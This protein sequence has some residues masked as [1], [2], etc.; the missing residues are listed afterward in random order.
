[1]WPQCVTVVVVGWQ[2]WRN[3]VRV[4]IR[5]LAVAKAG[6]EVNWQS[7][8]RAALVHWVQCLHL[9]GR[10]NINPTFSAILLPTTSCEKCLFWS[11]K[12]HCVQLLASD[13]HLLG[14]QA[15][16]NG[17]QLSETQ[18]EK[19]YSNCLLWQQTT[20]ESESKHW[21][22]WKVWAVRNEIKT[23]FWSFIE[24]MGT[25]A[26][27]VTAALKLNYKFSWISDGLSQRLLNWVLASLRHAFKNCRGV[28][29]STSAKDV[30][31]L[32]QFVCLFVYSKITGKVLKGF[33]LKFH[34]RWSLAQ[35]GVITWCSQSGS[36]NIWK[37]C[38]TLLHGATFNYLFSTNIT[39]Y[40]VTVKCEVCH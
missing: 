12:L 24:L 19:R 26:V 29:M 4:G 17:E 31:W 9:P 6:F 8:C 3:S 35:L 27:G 14:E 30:M 5:N 11:L 13:Y 39:D 16:F 32:V 20:S 18:K 38:V 2:W 21:S 33:A 10:S 15:A 1:M 37:D 25:A 22:Y 7:C 23:H 40:W 34:Q 28:S 36:R